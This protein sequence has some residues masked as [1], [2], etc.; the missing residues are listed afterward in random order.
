VLVC[1]RR[2]EELPGE[3][4]GVKCM[5]IC[6]ATED[7]YA[8]GSLERSDDSYTTTKGF[9]LAVPEEIVVRLE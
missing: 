3:A 8:G 2:F 5:P 4:V 9:M 7:A 6:F 1:W